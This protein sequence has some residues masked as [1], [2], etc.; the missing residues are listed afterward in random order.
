MERKAK[1]K[2]EEGR[3][4]GVNKKNEKEEVGKKRVAHIGDGGAS[5]GDVT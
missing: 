5:R 1:K 4:G 3:E 2:E